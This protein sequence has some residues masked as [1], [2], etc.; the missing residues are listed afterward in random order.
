MAGQFALLAAVGLAP[1]FRSGR[2][3]PVPPVAVR[4]GTGL[5]L[6]GGTLVAWG[7]GALGRHLTVMPDPGAQAELVQRGPYQYARHPIYG[8]LILLSCGWSVRSGSAASLGLTGALTALL[9]AKAGYEERAL[10]ARFAEYRAYQRR[11]RRFI[12]F[13]V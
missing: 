4:L 5:M 12:P 10:A 13:V 11:V 3:A 6:A 1:L 2:R 7:G 9:R 8:G